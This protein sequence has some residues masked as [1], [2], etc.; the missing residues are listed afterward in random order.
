VFAVDRADAVG[1]DY[2]ARIPAEPETVVR[3]TNSTCGESGR[4]SPQLPTS[5]AVSTTLG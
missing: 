3:S 5:I 2:A 4:V 1:V